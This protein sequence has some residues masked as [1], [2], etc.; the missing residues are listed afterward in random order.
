MHRSVLNK[1]ASPERTNWL[2]KQQ[3]VKSNVSDQ[4][5]NVARWFSRN[6]RQQAAAAEKLLREASIGDHVAR[7]ARA[8]MSATG[9]RT[10]VCRP[11]DHT[12]GCSGCSGAGRP[13]GSC[14]CS[15]CACST[16]PLAGG[17]QVPSFA[18]AA[19]PDL[20]RVSI[21]ELQEFLQQAHAELPPACMGRSPPC[22]D[23]PAGAPLEQA[24][25]K[26]SESSTCVD[27]TFACTS[28][29][30]MPGGMAESLRAHFPRL[31]QSLAQPVSPPTTQYAVNTSHG[32]SHLHTFTPFTPSHGESRDRA[33]LEAAA[34]AALSAWEVQRLLAARDVP[35]TKGGTCTAAHAN[36]LRWCRA[37]RLQP[38]CMLC[39]TMCTCTGSSSSSCGSAQNGSCNAHGGCCNA[40][41]GCC[42]ARGGCCNAQGSCCNTGSGCCSAQIGCCSAHG[43]CRAKDRWCHCCGRSA[44]ARATRTLALRVHPD[45]HVMDRKADATAAFEFLQEAA[46]GLQSMLEEPASRS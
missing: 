24:G 7:A 46:H 29:N 43:G 35:T 4:P 6:E 27:G 22:A 42:N 9:A 40:R 33:L 20:S 31:E 17:D 28:K 36:I 11:A 32:P 12:L 10:G 18:D 16:C 14:Q 3:G 8:R 13:T 1:T 37:L 39:C 5:R 30:A 34:R 23:A 21:S 41:G 45:K 26:A 38:E 25:A 2:R 44:V 15:R 19:V